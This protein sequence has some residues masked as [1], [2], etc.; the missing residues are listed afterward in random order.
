MGRT[1][2]SLAAL[3][4][5]QVGVASHGCSCSNIT[6]NS[7]SYG[8]LLVHLGPRGIRFEVILG[9][10]FLLRVSV[11]KVITSGAV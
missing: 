5:C 4:E 9:W 10:C 1:R 11:Q 8:H 6:G 2:W 7:L 3:S